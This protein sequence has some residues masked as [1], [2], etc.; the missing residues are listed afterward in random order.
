MPVVL[1]E[2]ETEYPSFSQKKA[3]GGLKRGDSE[4]DEVIDN[5]LA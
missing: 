3:K 4:F 2:S 5:V 1:E